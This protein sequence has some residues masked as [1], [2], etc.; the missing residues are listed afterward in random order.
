MSDD[1]D[2]DNLDVH[3]DEQ[4]DSYV[5]IR[6]DDLKQI[7]S[8]ARK[9]GES[10]AEIQRE[11][12]TYKRRDLIRDAGLKDLTD[13]QVAAL[14][15]LVDEETPEKF[16]EEAISLGWATKPEPSEEE[17]RLAAEIDGQQQVVAAS[18]GANASN[19]TRTLKPGDANGWPADKRMRLQA[20]H[21]D[22]YE[23]LLREQEITLPAGFN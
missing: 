12:A 18:T 7:R 6:K 23:L 1:F 20:Q 11:L 5:R 9:R 2:L 14:A 22:L 10:T 17:Q 8:A 3:D 13:K 19:V 15:K 16:L 21:P 4:D